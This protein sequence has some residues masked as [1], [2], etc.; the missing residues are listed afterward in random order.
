MPDR[1]GLVNGVQQLPKPAE[2]PAVRASHQSRHVGQLRLILFWFE[3]PACSKRSALKQIGKSLVQ[4][5]DGR[6]GQLPMQ[7]NDK[8][9]T[10]PS[11]GMEIPVEL[12]DHV[13]RFVHVLCDGKETEIVRGNQALPQEMGS[14]EFGPTLPVGSSDFVDQD[15]RNNSRLAGLHQSQT[16]KSFVHRSK[17]A[18]KQGDGVGFFDEINL[19]G[20]KIVKNDQLRIAFDGLVGFLLE[21]QPNVQSEAIR[22]TGSALGGAHNSVAAACDNHVSVFAHLPRESFCGLVDFD[23]RAGTRR[24][25]NGDLADPLIRGKTLGRL[26]KLLER[27]IDQFEVRDRHRIAPHP[28]GSDNH[29][30]D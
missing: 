24:P 25:E 8:L 5:L 19:S 3:C 10:D 20:E 23:M 12:E 21:R 30:R 11:V 27:T 14:Q 9:L 17:A 28:Q 1:F 4:F 15:D 6:G 26:S 18:R 22:S 7:S 13:D 2:V 29:F 16:L